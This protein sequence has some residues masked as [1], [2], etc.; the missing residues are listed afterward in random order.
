MNIIKNFFSKILDKN[1]DLRIRLLN[2]ILTAAI[3]ASV[4]CII[5][6]C[7]NKTSGNITNILLSLVICFALWLSVARKKST[8]AAI[9][10]TVTA[11]CILM[12]AMFFFEGG[13][14]SGMPIW[15]IFTSLCTILMLP[16]IISYV[17]FVIGLV[18]SSS[19]MILA[20]RFPKR[21]NWLSENI[22]FADILQS[23]IIVSV[24]LAA[25]LISYFI[26]YD[27]QKKELEE[28]KIQLEKALEHVKK[29]DKAKTEFL[30]NMSHEIRTPI[31][32]V[33]GLDELILRESKEKDTLEYAGNIQSSGQ[34]LLS[35]INDILDFSKIESGKMEI[36][37]DSYEINSVL[38]DVYNLIITRANEKNLTVKCDINPDLPSKLFGDEIRI[39]QIITNLLTNAVKY[40]KE[41]CITLKADYKKV[42]EKNI[43]LEISVKD[44]GIGISSENI[45]KMFDSFQRVDDKAN[46]TIEGTGLG[47]AITKQL[48]T[49]MDGNIFVKSEVNKGSNF[50]VSIPQIIIDETGIGEFK[51]GITRT[52][53]TF[54]AGFEAPDAKILI[55]DDVSLNLK[56]M[57]GLLKKTK[58]HIDTALSGEECIELCNKTKYDVIFLDHMMPNM[59][60]IE[61]FRKMKS[62]PDFLNSKTPVIMLTANAILGAKEEYLEIGFSDYLS[63]PVKYAELETMLKNYLI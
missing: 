26:A 20:Y 25:I 27:N 30:A 3:I 54:K 33:L 8:L 45:E 1:L 22:I 2:G 6:N 50:T 35:L 11:N 36:K 21:C 9:I 49:L 57:T 31:N 43:L 32:A 44:T 24:L 29:A 38:I 58:V 18:I 62:I 17:L 53:G 42:T 13:Y 12:P 60:G 55:V 7:F 47:L 10:L 14:K 41:G 59:D 19:C 51:T 56:V 61:T 5:A 28:K 63:K 40:T 34:S 4:S 15:M 39:R 52:I 23:F 48:V 46:R 37:S 16:G